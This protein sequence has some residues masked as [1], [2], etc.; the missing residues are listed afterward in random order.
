MVNVVLQ[1]LFYGQ[2]AIY[3]ACGNTNYRLRIV[4]GVILEIVFCHGGIKSLLIKAYSRGNV[5]DKRTVKLKLQFGENL[6][7]SRASWSF[8]LAG[9]WALP[10]RLI[11]GCG[12]SIGRSE[13]ERQELEQLCVSAVASSLLFIQVRSSLQG[14]DTQKGQRERG[15]VNGSITL[16][17]K[18][19]IIK[20]HFNIYLVV[21]RLLFSVDPEE[22]SFLRVVALHLHHD[23]IFAGHL[24]GAAGTKNSWVLS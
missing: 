9:D 12:G 14:E 11:S 13:P 17:K 22:H 15:Y 19:S 1:I 6:S 4:L 20:E 23:V 5:L 8:I 10:W 24:F 2:S 3:N 16:K 18:N 7:L 21:L